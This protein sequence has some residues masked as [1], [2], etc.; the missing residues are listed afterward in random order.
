MQHISLAQKKE[1]HSTIIV[2]YYKINM[3]KKK[4]HGEE[5]GNINN[6]IIN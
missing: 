5:E 1:D 6:N 3:I 2:G 4:L